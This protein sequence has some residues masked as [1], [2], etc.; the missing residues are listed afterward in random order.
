MHTFLLTTKPVVKPE[1][2]C[3]G[4]SWK[5]EEKKLLVRRPGPWDF[6]LFWKTKEFECR[7]DIYAVGSPDM[8]FLRTFGI[9]RAEHHLWK[10]G[11]C[12]LFHHLLFFRFTFIW[13]LPAGWKARGLSGAPCCFLRYKPLLKYKQL[14][15]HMD[16]EQVLR[17]YF[18]RVYIWGYWWTEFSISL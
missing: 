13:K 16:Y 18:G 17:S 2:T 7:T 15:L 10:C 9:K 5:R 6:E 4:L 8:L 3:N 14:D 11:W 12:G 1:H